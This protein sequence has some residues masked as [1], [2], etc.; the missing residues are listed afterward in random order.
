MMA[1]RLM[2]IACSNSGREVSATLP[3]RRE[4]FQ[5]EFKVGEHMLHGNAVSAA[6]GKPDRPSVK[7]TAVLFRDRLSVIDHHLQSD[8]QRRPVCPDSVG[9]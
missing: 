2:V 6:L 1:L 4:V 9:Q 5:L 7:A 8:E 3:G